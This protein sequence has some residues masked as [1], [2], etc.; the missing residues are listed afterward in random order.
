MVGHITV[1]P[2]NAGIQR[3]SVLRQRILWTSPPGLRLSPERQAHTELFT[4]SQVDD[5]AI[6]ELSLP[7]GIGAL[8]PFQ[9]TNKV[10]S[11]HLLPVI[12]LT[13]GSAP[14]LDWK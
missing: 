7:R 13:T 5:E 6:S 4:T 1:I 2:A 8:P 14:R 9:A 3:M 11:P 10:Q 12:T